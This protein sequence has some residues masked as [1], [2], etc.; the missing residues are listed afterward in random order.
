MDLIIVS[1]RR[2]SQ[3]KVVGMKFRIALVPL[4]TSCWLSFFHLS[5]GLRHEVLELLT[6]FRQSFFRSA[7]YPERLF[8]ETFC[9]GPQLRGGND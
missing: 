3:G 7:I 8:N 1:P 5:T 2:L 9:D 4:V 6:R